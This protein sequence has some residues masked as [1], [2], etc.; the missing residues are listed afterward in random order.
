MTMKNIP[1]EI[2]LQLG[3]DPDINDD[4]KELREVTWCADRINKNDLKFVLADVR[5]NEV[6]VCECGNKLTDKEVFYDTCLQCGEAI[7]EQTER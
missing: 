1:K 2:Y 3:D 5:V 4:F 6:A 7:P